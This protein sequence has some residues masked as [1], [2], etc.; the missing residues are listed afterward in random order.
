[1]YLRIK[2][3]MAVPM[4]STIFWLGARPAEV[5][6]RFVGTFCLHLQGLRISRAGTSKKQATSSCRCR[7]LP[8]YT[9]VQS[10]GFYCLQELFENVLSTKEEKFFQ[11][12]FC[13]LELLQTRAAHLRVHCCYTSP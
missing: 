7:L 4:K 9:A 6:Y 8:N 12:Q 5:F 1:M 2:A 13:L 11:N 3:L 10:G